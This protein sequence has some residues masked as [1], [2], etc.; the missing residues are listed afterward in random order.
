[1]K[2]KFD[3]NTCVVTSS[4]ILEV[5]KLIGY[6]N[7]EDFVAKGETRIS[8]MALIHQSLYQSEE[9]LDKINFQSNVIYLAV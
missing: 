6:D 2:F 3:P 7:I 5:S 4:N 1:M 9:S 8:S